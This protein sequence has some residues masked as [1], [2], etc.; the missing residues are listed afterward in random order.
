MGDEMDFNPYY[1]VFPYRDFIKTEGIPIV[2]A[3][4]VDCHTVA[5]EPWERLGGLGAYVHLAGKSDFLSAYVVEIPLG[6]E[7]T[8]QQHMHDQLIP[9]TPRPR[10]P[11]GAAG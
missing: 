10:P 11:P 2:E 4:A 9:V 8:P 3:Y 1:G 7:P 5:L 6:G